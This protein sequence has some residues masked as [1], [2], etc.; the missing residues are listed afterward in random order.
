MYQNLL[1]IDII[2]NWVV[3]RA[4]AAALAFTIQKLPLSLHY[5]NTSTKQKQD[6]IIIQKALRTNFGQASYD[7]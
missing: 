2:R 6:V 5:R 1:Y 3:H 4:M 7:I